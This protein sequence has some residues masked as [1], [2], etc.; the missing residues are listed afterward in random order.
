[1]L[2]S[3]GLPAC[4]RAAI[5]EGWLRHAKLLVLLRGEVVRF[6]NYVEIAGF[7]RIKAENQELTKQ[8]GR[9]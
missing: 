5:W 1:M 3:D 7:I 9:T 6:G 2:R 8:L 4:G